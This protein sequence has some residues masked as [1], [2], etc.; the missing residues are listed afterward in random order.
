MAMAVVAA[1]FFPPAARPLSPHGIPHP[2]GQT[3]QKTARVT[4]QLI[5][6]EPPPERGELSRR[7]LELGR[8]AA[9]AR[10]RATVS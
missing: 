6:R 1:H 5:A 7:P 8:P 10:A 3:C 9:R 2:T 4:G